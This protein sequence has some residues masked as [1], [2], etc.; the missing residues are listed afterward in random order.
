MVSEGLPEKMAF[1]KIL[2][3]DKMGVMFMWEKHL[4]RVNSEC[5]AWTLMSVLKKK[6]LEFSWEELSW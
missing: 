4:R 3:E 1:K 6:Q 2:K 5:K